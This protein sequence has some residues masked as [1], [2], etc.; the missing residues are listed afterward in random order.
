M[1]KTK[2]TEGLDFEKALA[3]LEALV[4]R[5]EKGDLPLEQALESFERG[6][7]LTR[8][9]QSALK[10]AEQKVQVLV[11]RDGKQSLEPFER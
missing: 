6:I 5:M 9:C 8:L 2:G 1:K 4:A 11:S 7:E 10:D 3:E